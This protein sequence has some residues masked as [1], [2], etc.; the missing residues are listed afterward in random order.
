MHTTIRPAT[1]TDQ[2]AATRVLADAFAGDP[3]AR[4]VLGAPGSRRAGALAAVMRAPVDVSRRRG[5]L[6][7]EYDEH[8]SVGAVSTWVPA[9]QR[10]VG[11]VDAVRANALSVPITVGAPTMFRLGKD[12][13]DL[14]AVLAEHLRPGDAYL[15]VLGARRD[16][17]G[18]GL[19]RAVVDETCRQ[20]AARGFRRVV[21]NTDNPANVQ[22]YAR[23]G[24]ELHDTARRSSGLT[25]H[26]LIRS[27]ASLAEER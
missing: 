16:L 7:L 5:G 1:T 23:L 3:W 26:V 14:D 2:R 12:E 9:D 4:Y 19:G 13:R 6:V 15:W 10:H 17:H 22:M 24:F 8:G 20:A 25:A 21:L 27:V 18:R 11:V